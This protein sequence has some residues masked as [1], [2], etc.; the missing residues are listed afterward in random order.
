MFERVFP[1]TTA[2]LRL[3]LLVESDAPEVRALTDDPAIVISFLPRP[4]KLED[5]QTLIGGLDQG[6]HRF[7]GL[8]AGG[9]LIGILGMFFHDPKN[10][11]LGYW[12]GTTHQGQGYA[13]E[14]LAGAVAALRAKL[15]DVRV[16]AECRDS[17]L[18]S[19][20]VL[21]KAGFRATGQAGQ[22]AGMQRY[23]LSFQ[24]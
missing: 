2:R 19:R 9:A 7:A 5:A 20:R 18:A 4:F 22:R 1:I 15:P 12:I 24:P 16:F 11:E 3:A 13:S 17:N 14:A 6:R 10:V 21:E 23:A 8:R